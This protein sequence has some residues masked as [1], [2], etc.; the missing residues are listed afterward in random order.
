MRDFVKDFVLLKGYIGAALT[1]T[2]LFSSSSSGQIEIDNVLEGF[3]KADFRPVYLEDSFLPIDPL[4]SHLSLGEI[5]LPL[6]NEHPRLL[7]SRQRSAELQS[8]IRRRPYS[9]WWNTLKSRAQGALMTDLSASG[10]REF[11]RA[12]YAE[13]CAFTYFIEGDG[14]YLQKA[15][16][17]LLHISPAPHVVNLEGGKPGDTWGDFVSASETMLPY[18]VAYDIVAS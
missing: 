7:F 4:R 3:I 9:V 15:K 1:F 14:R 6:S 8:R 2:I 17:A 18:L 13:A 10:L 16:E 11:D 5:R 12:V